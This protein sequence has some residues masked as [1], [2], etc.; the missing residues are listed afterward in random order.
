M[1]K[2]K[3]RRKGKPRQR[4]PEQRAPKVNPKP[5]PTWVPYVGV[6]L[7]LLGVTVIIVNYIPGF[8]ERNWILI[9]G[10]VLMGGGFGF[11]MKWR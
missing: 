1:P 5:S 4:P 9:A 2:S 11:L 6:G 10:F 8:L 7:I 3:H